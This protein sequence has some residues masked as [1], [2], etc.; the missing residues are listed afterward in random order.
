MEKLDSE[1]DTVIVLRSMKISAFPQWI[2]AMILHVLVPARL[3]DSC[4]YVV[5]AP[6]NEV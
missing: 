6:V 2:Q 5:L 3:W 4:R 1:L